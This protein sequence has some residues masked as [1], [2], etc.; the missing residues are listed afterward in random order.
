MTTLIILA[1]I[2]AV[3]AFIVIFFKLRKVPKCGSLTLITGGVKTGKSTLAVHLSLRM[4][5]KARRKWKVYMILRKV[6]RFLPVREKPLFY[7]NVP[8]AGID[9]VEVTNELLLRK[10]R[11]A[12]RSII[13]IQEASLVADSQMVKNMNI[14]ERLLLLNKLIGHETRGGAI[15]YDTQSIQDCH[16]TIKR[17]V[18]SYLWIHHNIKIPFF[19]LVY[20]RE[21]FYSEDGNG[22]NVFNEDVE[23][24]LLRIIIPKSIWKR[25]DA[26]CYSK[27]TDHLEVE[28]KTN[29]I[30]KRKFR[31]S[32][33]QKR[34]INLKLRTDKIFS[35]RKALKETQSEKPEKKTLMRGNTK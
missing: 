32:M 15:I 21:M 4:Y 5:K 29:Y 20:V 22:I 2:A 12:Y 13:Y 30:Q 35:I 14:N 10:K 16:Y 19:V 24:T 27:L 25:F 26:Y 31:M 1:A 7:S 33:K 34:T 17:S 18:S 28:N 9:Y 8:I 11:F 6:L 23:E 3:I